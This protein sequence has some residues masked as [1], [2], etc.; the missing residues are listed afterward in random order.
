MSMDFGRFGLAAA[1]SGGRPARLRRPMTAVFWT[2]GA[3]VTPLLLAMIVLGA[4]AILRPR[5]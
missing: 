1:P 5:E 2:V 3:I 4:A